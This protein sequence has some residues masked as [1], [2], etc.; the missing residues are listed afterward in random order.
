MKKLIPSRND[1][2]TRDPDIFLH[3]GKYYHC[4]SPDGTTVCV[5]CAE[6]LEDLATADPLCVYTAEPGTPYSKQLWAPELHILDGLC[7][8]YL[9]CDDG[10]NYNHRMYVL[11][12]GSNDPQ[13]PY[14]MHG[15][16]GDPTDRWAIDGTILSHNGNR[17]MV[18]A[19]WEGS[20]NVAQNLYIARMDS[21]YSFDTGRVMI[22]QPEYDWEKNGCLG[23]Q[24]LPYINEGPFPFY[25]G[26]DLY[27]IYSASGCWCKDYCLAFLKLTGD[28]PL[29]PTHW[30]KHPAPIFSASEEC[31]GAGHCTVIQTEEKNLVFFHAWD[32]SQHVTP[33]SGLL[34]SVWM[35]EITVENGVLSVK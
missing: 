34:V 35:G 4:F 31:Q 5:S 14:R 17:Y 29:N 9:A 8:I 18:W 7:Y 10:D 26:S 32:A 20:E 16:I 15:Q 19:G 11:E 23:G 6:R 30:K 28:D 22:S 24:E 13:A 21:P 2:T 25:D 27:L 12:N 1:C 3:Q 33:D